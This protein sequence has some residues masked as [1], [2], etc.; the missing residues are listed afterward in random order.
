[1]GSMA[2]Q[3]AKVSVLDST[4]ETRAIRDLGARWHDRRRYLGKSVQQAEGIVTRAYN[5]GFYLQPEGT[6]KRIYRAGYRVEPVGFWTLEP[7]VEIEI[8]DRPT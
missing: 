5:K 2:G 7:Q 6:L 3:F 1:M 4:N 8:Q